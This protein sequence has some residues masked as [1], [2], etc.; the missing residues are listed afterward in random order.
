MKRLLLLLLLLPSLAWGQE[1][2]RMNPYILGGGA[3][4]AATCTW[5]TAWSVADDT[6]SD[7][8]S[9]RNYRQI[10]IANTSSYSGTKVRVTFKATAGNS[11][12]IDGCSIGES[13]AN[14]DYDAAPTRVTF[15][16]GNNSGTA[17]AGGTLLSDEMTFTFDKTKRYI[18]HTWT[19]AKYIRYNNNSRTTQYYYTTPNDGTLTQS[20]SYSTMTALSTGPIKVEVCVPD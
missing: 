18:V 7:D 13:T 8:G 2:A 11:W 12:T 9:E 1:Y 3:S 14:D 15:G 20:V 17:S 19:K 4:A 5:Q 16:S 6:D 10:I